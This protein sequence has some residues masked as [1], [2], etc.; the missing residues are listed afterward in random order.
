MT[1]RFTRNTAREKTAEM[2]ATDR[3]VTSGTVTTD[4]LPTELR[5]MSKSKKTSCQH[6][7]V[8]STISVWLYSISC[9]CLFIYL[10]ASMSSPAVKLTVKGKCGVDLC[11]ANVSKLFFF[12]FFL[13]LLLSTI[14]FNTLN[15]F[16][17]HSDRHIF[18]CVR[19]KRN[20]LTLRS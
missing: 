12:F 19:T 13:V 11:G 3:T 20:Y 4:G 18:V 10:W 16:W 7:T 9:F 17:Y 14:R 15:C 8:L 6:K 5:L 1:V 2:G